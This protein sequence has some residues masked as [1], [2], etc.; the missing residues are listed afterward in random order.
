MAPCKDENDYICPKLKKVPCKGVE[1]AY[2]VHTLPVGL[3]ETGQQDSGQGGVLHGAHQFG[4]QQDQLGLQMSR[5][6]CRVGIQKFC[7]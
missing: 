7:H 4:D 6:P 1:T 3:R 2:L 5:E